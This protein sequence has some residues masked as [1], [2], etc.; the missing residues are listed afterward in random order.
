V[1]VVVEAGENVEEFAEE[2]CEEGER[3]GDF[4]VGLVEWWGCVDDV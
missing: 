4:V 3:G 1:V 2:D